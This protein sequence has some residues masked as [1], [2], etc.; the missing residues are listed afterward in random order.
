[1][2]HTGTLLLASLLL[3]SSACS[4]EHSV[5]ERELARPVAESRSPDS[6]TTTQA[7]SGDKAATA[8]ATTGGASHSASD[9]FSAQSAKYDTQKISFDPN[10][11]QPVTVVPDRKVIRN[12]ELTIELDSPVEAQRRIASIAESHGGF[13]VTSESRQDDRARGAQAAQIVSVEMRVPAADFDAVI[14]AVRGVGGRVRDEKISGKDVTEEYIDLEARLKAQRALEAQIL[15][16]MKRAQRVS[17]ALEVN[18]Q[19]AQVRSEIE[20]LEGR[21]RFLENQSSLSTIKITIEPPAPLVSAETTGFFSNVRR[22]FGDGVDFAAALVVGVIRVV[23]TLLPVAVLLCLP[24]WLAWRYL[25]RR[26]RRA[27]AVEDWR[28]AAPPAGA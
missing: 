13:V 23:V 7:P 25:R 26:L 3:V 8:T 15:E 14:N 24:A 18:E 9:E 17:D 16:I 19:L 10:A 22:A 4:T 12:A 20:R 21:R 28:P 11:Q 1:M 27:R 2:R 6:A 5:A